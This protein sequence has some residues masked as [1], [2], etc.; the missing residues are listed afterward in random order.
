MTCPVKKYGDKSNPLLEWL[1]QAW[2]E[3]KF[4]SSWNKRV[5]CF[6][7]YISM[8]NFTRSNQ[9]QME[10]KKKMLLKEVSG[11]FGSFE[12]LERSI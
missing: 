7:L 5:L 2:S 3:S 6:D 11:Y 9:N 10:F 1:K 4:F 8:K 12:K